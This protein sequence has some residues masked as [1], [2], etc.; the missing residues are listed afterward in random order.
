MMPVGD[1]HV[2]C[3]YQ[4]PRL[5]SLDSGEVVTRW[6]DLD[7]GNQVSSISEDA[8]IPPLAIDVEHKRFAVFGPAGIT[9]IQIDLEG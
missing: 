6:D 2:V 1:S 3:F 4:H 7:T 5:V 9:V 8:T